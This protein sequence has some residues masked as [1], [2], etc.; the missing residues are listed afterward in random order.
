M[1][2]RLKIDLPPSSRIRSRS[3]PGSKQEGTCRWAVLMAVCAL[4]RRT[5]PVRC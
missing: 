2:A 1:S 3:S 5:A 4:S